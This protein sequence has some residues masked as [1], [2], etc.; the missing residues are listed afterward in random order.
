MLT[1][2]FLYLRGYTLGGPAAPAGSATAGIIAFAGLSFLFFKMVHVVV[3][4]WSGTI[5]QLLGRYLNYCLN[6]T[7]VLM[8]PIQRFQDFS[9]QWRGGERTAGLRVL[10]HRRK[11]RAARN[12]QGVRAGAA[13][14]AIR[15]APGLPIERM[16][17]GELLLGI[18][19]FYIFLYLD[20][21]GYCDI[22][23]GI[24]ILMGLRPPENFRF[25]FLARDVSGTGCG[26]TVR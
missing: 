5:D 2:A 25:P 24:G 23:I 4:S 3:D 21:S 9:T 16:G 7:T 11:P 18:Y 26:C 20:F 15:S 22:V 10:R 13:S 6:F 19:A 17:G 14:L 1:G 12:G 8:G